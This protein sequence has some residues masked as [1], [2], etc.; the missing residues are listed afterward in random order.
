[1]VELLRPSR[2]NPSYTNI[3][4][5]Y[6]LGS[7][8]N[9][10]IISCGSVGK[11]WHWKISYYVSSFTLCQQFQFCLKHRWRAEQAFRSLGSNKCTQWYVFWSFLRNLTFQYWTGLGYQNIAPTHICQFIKPAESTLHRLLFNIFVCL[12]IRINKIGDFY[13][14]KFYF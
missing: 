5:K 11:I 12:N 14:Y 7:R 9:D 4:K 2:R 10:S 1:M 13:R 6:F 3:K 8:C